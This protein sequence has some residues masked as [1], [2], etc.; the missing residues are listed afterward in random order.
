MPKA[1]VHVAYMCEICG[2]PHIERVK[3]VKPHAMN[4]VTL[5]E[6]ILAKLRSYLRDKRYDKQYGIAVDVVESDTELS[7]GYPSVKEW[8][9]RIGWGRVEQIAYPHRKQS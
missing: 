9:S 2:V 8:I 3:V 6:Y 4:D 7:L 5:E 1:V